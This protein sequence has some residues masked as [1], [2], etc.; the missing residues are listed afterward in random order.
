MRVE[1][2]PLVDKFECESGVVEI[3]EEKGMNS[4]V[5]KALGFVATVSVLSLVFMAGRQ[6]G[7]WQG[8]STPVVGYPQGVS[9]IKESHLSEAAAAATGFV[10][11]SAD[12]ANSI[13]LI[14][15]GTGKTQLRF[16]IASTKSSAGAQNPLMVAAQARSKAW[17]SAAVKPASGGADWIAPST[18]DSKLGSSNTMQYLLTDSAKAFPS[19]IPV[20][21]KTY[22]EYA[23]YGENCATHLFLMMKNGPSAATS[24]GWGVNNDL[25]GSTWTDL[26]ISIWANANDGVSGSNPL[27]NA[28]WTILFSTSTGWTPKGK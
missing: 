2:S 10:P 27:G 8:Q 28:Y 22:K 1:R 3:N 14:R 19:Y 11:G 15:K 9:K 21:G 12:L 18:L 25:K 16:F 5:T 17:G 20:S 13:N 26:A 6:T 24:A 7:S 4:L 23:F